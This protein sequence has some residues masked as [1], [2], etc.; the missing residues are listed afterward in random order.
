M[1][2]SYGANGDISRPG[3]S[4]WPLVITAQLFQVAA[5]MQHVDE[6]FLWLAN[7][8]VQNLDIQVVQFW[9]LQTKRTGQVFTQLRTLVFQDDSLPQH[10]VTNSQVVTTAGNILI[11][12]RGFMIQKVGGLFSSF[13]AELLARYGLYYCSCFFLSSNLLLPPV[14]N[15]FSH[16][17][18]LPMPLSLAVLV[19]LRQVPLQNTLSGLNLVLEQAIQIAGNNGLL[20]PPGS[21]STH[22]LSNG[23]PQQEMPL[24]LTELIPHRLEDDTLLKSSNPF[25]SSDII[26]DK[27]ARRLYNAIDGHR[28]VKEICEMTGMD[29]TEAQRALK[30]LIAHH[31]IQFHRPGG[32]SVDGSELLDVL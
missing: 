18:D 14:Y 5:N 26:T 31:R 20:L 1:M 11:Q 6:L 9:G 8:S 17:E 15:Q 19:F 32:Q 21:T 27:Q 25:A 28:A 7:V 23:Y 2:D 3:A 29:L 12:R 24:V 4:R 30:I 16:A 22:S 10:V 13:Q